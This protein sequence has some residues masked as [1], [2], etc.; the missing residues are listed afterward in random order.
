MTHAA[1]LVLRWCF[2]DLHLRRVQWFANERNDASIKGGERLGLKIEGRLRWERVLPIGKEGEDLPEWAREEEEAAGRGLG[3]HSVL[4][5]IGWD[6]WRADGKAKVAT[7]VAREVKPR[8]L[9]RVA[10]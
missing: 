10:S 2:D 7:L 5:A 9:V 4:L 3:R 8:T 1:G 6:A